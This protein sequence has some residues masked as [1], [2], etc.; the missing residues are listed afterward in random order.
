MR[1]IT[2]SGAPRLSACFAAQEKSEMTSFPIALGLLLLS[3]QSGDAAAVLSEGDMRFLEEMTAAVVQESRVSAGDSV[4]PYGPNVTGDTV[5]RPGGREDYPA[6]W[7][8]DYA[9]SI[10]SGQITIA[11][12]RHML[13]LTAKHQSDTDQTLK[14][15]SLVPAG[16][17]ADHITFGDKPIYFPGTLD[18]FEG[19]GGERWGKLPSL[20][21]AFFFIHMAHCYLFTTK[22]PSFL[23]ETVNGKPLKQRLEEAYRMPP[24]RDDSGLV[25]VT[26]ATRGVTFGFVDSVYHTGDLLFCSLLKFR[27]AGQLKHFFR[28]LGDEERA[29]FYSRERQRLKAAITSAFALPSGFYKASTGLSAQPDV[30]GTAF[31]V[32]ISAFPE[33]QTKAACDALTKAYLSDSIAWHGN[34]RHVPTTDDFSAETAWEKA[35]SPKNRYQNG[36]YWG[37]PTGWVCYA[38]AQVDV[39]SA[40]KLAAEYIAELRDGDFR[41]GPDFGSPWECLHPD[42]DF[43]QNPIYMTSVACPFFAFLRLNAELSSIDSDAPIR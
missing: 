17:I 25:T 13:F 20:D 3:A 15:G 26:E 30:W 6:F 19:Q 7:I 23:N 18:D 21:D 22:D 29:E 33:P 32:F 37:T 1:F 4:G 31:G 28:S 34:I 10:E 11:E 42:G 35:G 27:A 9:M 39:P 12:Q 36:A 40:K 2:H 41:K 8:R 14:S 24:S 5:I 43:R 38:I 16:S